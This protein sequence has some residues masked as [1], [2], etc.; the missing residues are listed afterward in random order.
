MAI[1]WYLFEVTDGVQ[2]KVSDLYN[3]EEWAG[4]PVYIIGTGASM[5]VFPVKYL[6]NKY[7]ILL[8]DAHRFF[9]HLQPIAFSNHRNFLVDS[10]CRYNVVKG[11]Y[12]GDPHPEKTDNHVPWDDPN[13]HVFSY[14]QTPWDTISHF[15]PKCLWAERD[16]YW[17]VEGGSVSIFALQF[18]LLAGFSEIH[19]VGCDCGEFVAH[20]AYLD[21]KINTSTH[22]YDQYVLG[23]MTMIREAEEKFGVPVVNV[24]PYPGYGREQALHQ[25]LL[26]WR[27]R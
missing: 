13:Y 26:T 17:N 12:R 10:K 5:D 27:R 22:Q 1:S 8:N 7:C 24:G 9:P 21:Q 19:L 14:R 23:I 15:A 3:K 6:E 18:A 20:Q 25:Q 11:R 4:K 16:F 2:M